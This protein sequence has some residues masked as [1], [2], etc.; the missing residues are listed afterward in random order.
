LGNEKSL[1]GHFGTRH[2]KWK[3]SCGAKVVFGELKRKKKKEKRKV[4]RGWGIPASLECFFAAIKAFIV[5][6][7]V[8]LS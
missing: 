5:G 6:L 2:N 8:G 3:T 4:G 1:K 7:S